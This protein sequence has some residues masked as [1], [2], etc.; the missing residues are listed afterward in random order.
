MQSGLQLD[1]GDYRIKF[2]AK[3]DKWFDG[4]HFNEHG[5]WL[6]MVVAENVTD[7]LI[8]VWVKPYLIDGQPLQAPEDWHEQ[9]IEHLSVLDV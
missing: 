9:V 6:G 7:D 2:I 5:A 3:N 1:Y 4:V 8:Y